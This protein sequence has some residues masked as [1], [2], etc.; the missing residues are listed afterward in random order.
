MAESE[1]VEI[2]IKNEGVAVTMEYT[3]NN[4]DIFKNVPSDLLCDLNYQDTHL[5]KKTM[6]AKG[7]GH[8]IQ[9]NWLNNLDL[10]NDYRNQ[11]FTTAYD[12]ITGAHS[13]RYKGNLVYSESDQLFVP[14]PWVEEFD[15][16]I[17]RIMK[18]MQTQ[19]EVADMNRLM[20]LK[21]LFTFQ[22]RMTEEV[23]EVQ[24][25]SMGE[26][27]PNSVRFSGGV[28][29]LGELKD[30][31]GFGAY[32]KYDP[33]IQLSEHMK[34]VVGDF[35]SAFP[36]LEINKSDEEDSDLFDS[37]KRGVKALE[38]WHNDPRPEFQID[39]NVKDPRGVSPLKASLLEWIENNK[40]E[41]LRLV[42]LRGCAV[43][44]PGEDRGIK[45]C[46]FCLFVPVYCYTWTDDV[47][48]WVTCPNCKIKV[49]G[50]ACVIIWNTIMDSM[51]DAS[52]QNA[53]R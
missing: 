45:K 25:V 28:P 47:P 34:G 49:D 5:L 13:I 42:P 2:N 10:V 52:K 51:E 38:D 30:N 14:G 19:N 40:R 22:D 3:I 26:V 1:K 36:D 53:I 6:W 4:W 11:V 37:I 7:R 24:S 20:D 31:P 16:E 8:A 50:D 21:R 43:V 41:P 15:A 12:T 44:A 39:P 48:E 46:Q 23:K 27:D 9:M 33:A 32:M 18:I 17:M 29:Y 35:K